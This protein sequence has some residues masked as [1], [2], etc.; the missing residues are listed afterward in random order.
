[1]YSK[2][3]REIHMN[4][5]NENEHPE[6]PSGEDVAQR[7]ASDNLKELTQ[8]GKQ[9]LEAGQ[10]LLRNL[11]ELQRRVDATNLKSQLAQRPWLIAVVALIGG[12]AGWRFF[13]R[14]H[15]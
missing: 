12:I 13:A 8:A 3:G 1:V 15:G 7:S 2:A 10:H 11:N 4:M 9:L 14:R 6:E 5:A